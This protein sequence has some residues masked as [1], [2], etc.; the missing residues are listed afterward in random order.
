MKIELVA[1][2]AALVVASAAP[3]MADAQ[4]TPAPVRTVL[5]QH[6][7]SAPGREVVQVRVDVPP[8]AEIARH[9]HF[10]EEMVYV[11]SGELEYRADG[12][13][14]TIVK[15]GEVA[16]V[17]AGTVHAA[18]NVGGADA[19]LLATYVVEKGKP[20]LTPAP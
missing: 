16:F 6:D 7:L 17:P 5:Q 9:T 13:P 11:L 4:E 8:G 19:S 2:I 18:R 20:L 10:G 15:A 3:T 12:Q 1:A 14:V